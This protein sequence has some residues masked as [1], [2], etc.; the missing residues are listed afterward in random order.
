MFP[1]QLLP[2][3]LQA[4]QEH[5]KV[6]ALALTSPPIL[7]HRHQ[8]LEGIENRQLCKKYQKGTL[9]L[10]YLKVFTVHK[11]IF[12]KFRGQHTGTETAPS[13][14]S[15]ERQLSGDGVTDHEIRLKLGGFSGRASR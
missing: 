8:H 3:N 6:Q 1:K 2:S 15:K 12:L 11:I 10:T 13:A 4:M 7:L 5:Q 9:I 14:T